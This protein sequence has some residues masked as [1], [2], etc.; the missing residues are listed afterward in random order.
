MSAWPA[1]N[2]ACRLR[3][4]GSLDDDERGTSRARINEAWSGEGNAVEE[5]PF[6]VS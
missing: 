3:G 1:R 4:R 2:Q 6:P 5:D